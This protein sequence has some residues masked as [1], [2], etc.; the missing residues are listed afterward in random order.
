VHKIP[1]P[2]RYIQRHWLILLRPL[3][4]FSES[5]NAYVLRAVGRTVGPVLRVE[6]RR[7]SRRVIAVERRRESV[8]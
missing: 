3:F 6:R 1:R 4:R 8:A 5:R 2:R 7:R